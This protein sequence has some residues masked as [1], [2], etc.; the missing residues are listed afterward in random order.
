MI[1]KLGKELIHDE[2][3]TQSIFYCFLNQL[4]GAKMNLFFKKIFFLKE[5]LYEK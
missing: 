4:I 2:V 3:N 5:F 1:S